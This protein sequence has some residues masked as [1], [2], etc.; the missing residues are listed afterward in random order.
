MISPPN[1][2][3][4]ATIVMFM[5]AGIVSFVSAGAGHF[6]QKRPW[7]VPIFLVLLGVADI[8]FAIL[9]GQLVVPGFPGGPIPSATG[10]PY[11]LL[12][13]ISMVLMPLGYVWTGYRELAL[14]RNHTEQLE[15]KRRVAEHEKQKLLER[16]DAA[17]EQNAQQRQQFFDLKQLIISNVSHELRTPMA[18]ALGF[19]DMI[20]TGTY[21]QVDG[22]PLHEPLMTV[23]T[24][25]QRMVAVVERM[26]NTW[27]E[28]AF[29]LT[30][31]AE[32]GRQLLASNGIW[33]NTR[34]N[35][36]DVT[37]TS[38]IPDHLWVMGDTEMLRTAV[39]ELLNNAI[40]FGSTD[41]HLAMFEEDSEIVTQVRDNGIGVSRKYHRQIFE[42]L[43]QIQMGSTR[44]YEGAGMGLAA[45]ESVAHAHDGHTYVQSRLGQGATFN[46]I[47][48]ATSV[49]PPALD[50]TTEGKD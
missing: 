5:T 35:P 13:S 49:V 50:V 43:Y 24:N 42:P 28:P 3:V 1:F 16:L 38:D 39:F 4:W 7:P 25:T 36:A 37:I 27:R 40:K 14:I 48:P 34:R 11:F 44:K 6:V 17:Q 2:F 30:D 22:T 31:L 20:M 21:G 29:T 26:V 23:H 8:V 32:I 33:L 47:I 45:V 12:I 19:V 41:I 10:R 15:A 9:Y 18:I 46:L